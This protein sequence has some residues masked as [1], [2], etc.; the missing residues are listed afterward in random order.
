LPTFRSET[1]ALLARRGGEQKEC[2]NA[3]PLFLSNHFH[4]EDIKLRVATSILIAI[5]S[6]LNHRS[7]K[8]RRRKPPLHYHT[9]SSAEERFLH[10]AIQNSKLDTR[11]VDGKLE[12]PHA[13]TFYPSIE[14]FEQG[15]MGYIEK[16]RR[17]AMPFGICKIV[18]PQGWNPPFCKYFRILKLE[19]R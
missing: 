12:I 2:S 11:R 19:C 17:K 13:P 5:M 6:S 14:E 8:R 3:T 9:T 15:P 1:L 4:E 7:G 10:Q 16:I 18:P